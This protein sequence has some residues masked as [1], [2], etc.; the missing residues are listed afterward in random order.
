MYG[1]TIR[2][3]MMK[4]GSTTPACHGSKNTSISCR[5]RKYHGAFDGFGVRVGLAGSS[6]GAST[7]SDHTISKTMTKMAHRNS[8]AHQVRPGVHL[9]VARARS[10]S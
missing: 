2:P 6:S 9:V 10:P 8:S 7:S 1:M 3:M 5:P 4:V